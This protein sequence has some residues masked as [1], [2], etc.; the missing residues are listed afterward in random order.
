M[1]NMETEVEMQVNPLTYRVDRYPWERLAAVGDILTIVCNGID[2]VAARESA[3]RYAKR[4]GW[5]ISGVI[6]AKENPGR[7]KLMRIK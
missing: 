7:L 2:P 6:Q 5:K 1:V 4:H 3:Y